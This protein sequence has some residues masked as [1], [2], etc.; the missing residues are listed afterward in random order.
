VIDWPVGYRACVSRFL[1][2]CNTLDEDIVSVILYGSLARGDVSPGA[3][4]VLDAVVVLRD[5]VFLEERR[6]S[7]VVQGLTR[8]YKDI[9]LT[10]LPAHPFHYLSLSEIEKSC[11]SLYLPILESNQLSRTIYGI[12]VRARAHSVDRDRTFLKGSFFSVT[13]P[14]WQLGELQLPHNASV[15]EKARALARVRRFVMALPKLA[16]LVLEVG[17]DFPGVFDTIRRLLPTV[18]V[19][20][21]EAL[22]RHPH[23]WQEEISSD[24]INERIA[25]LLTLYDNLRSAVVGRL[26]TDGRWQPLYRSIIAP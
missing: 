21:L 26:E 6:H 5:N 20:G 1:E 16:C 23:Q 12:D 4:D 18:D 25:K 15:E 7:W 11:W 3:S 24:E 10:G 9:L 14:L 13:R 8:A 22:A 19:N 2:T 17:A